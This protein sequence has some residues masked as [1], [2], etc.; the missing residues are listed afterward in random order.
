MLVSSPKLEYKLG[1]RG[2]RP[3][4]YGHVVSYHTQ[5]GGKALDVRVMTMVMVVV[6]VVLLQKFHNPE[7]Q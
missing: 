3:H 2:M 6:L 1:K 5:T 4:G 7:G